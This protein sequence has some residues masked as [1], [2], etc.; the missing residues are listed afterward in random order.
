M[1]IREGLTFDDVLL[2]P[3]RSEVTPNQVSTATRLTK[4]IRLNIPIV[5]AAMDTVTESRLAIAMAQAGGM[6]HGDGQAPFGHR[7]HGRRDQGNAQFD[8]ARQ[9][10][11]CA[12]LGGHDVGWTGFKQNIVEGEPFAN[13]HR[14]LRFAGRV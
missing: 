14:S 10:G 12:H 2:E 3:G 13:L 7:V 1:E 6:G 11:G 8:L 4:D 9:L 5:S